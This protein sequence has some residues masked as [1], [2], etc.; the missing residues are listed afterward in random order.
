MGAGG[1]STRALLNSVERR[2]VLDL[3]GLRVTV[4]GWERC[5]ACNG[6]GKQPGGPGGRR[7]ENCKGMRM[8]ASV[9]IEGDIT[10]DLIASSVAGNV[11]DLSDVA[12]P[13]SVGKV[14]NVRLPFRVATKLDG[15]AA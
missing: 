15:S 6:S 13:R 8:V 3:L 11:G 14:P 7:C 4:L 1:A 2:V 12:P 10:D 9:M 5:D